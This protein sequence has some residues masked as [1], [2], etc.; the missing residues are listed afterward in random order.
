[1]PLAIAN[2]YAQ[3]LGEVVSQAGSPVGPEAVLQQLGAFQQLLAESAELNTVL[4][5]PAVAPAKKRALVASLGERLGLPVPVRNFLF[6]VIDHRRMEL[7]PEIIK[8]LR[9]WLD[10]K[11]GIARLDVRAARALDQAQQS[12]VEQAFE[13]LTGKQVRAIFG[14]DPDLLGGAMVRHGSVVYDGSLRAQL[15]ALKQALVQGF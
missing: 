15:Q 9:D 7:L 12:S 13:R 5:S 4:I 8:A 2:R 1:M 6:V 10:Q 3:A 14:V 11:L